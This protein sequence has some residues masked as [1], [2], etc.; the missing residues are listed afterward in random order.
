MIDGNRSILYGAGSN[1]WLRLWYRLWHRLWL[2]LRLIYWGVGGDLNWGI[3]GD[4]NWSIITAVDND[5]IVIISTSNDLWFYDFRDLFNWNWVR[6]VDNHVT[7]GLGTVSSLR[8][9]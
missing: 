4:L 9:I 3:G 8:V 1:E 6:Y 2:W 5:L 7:Y